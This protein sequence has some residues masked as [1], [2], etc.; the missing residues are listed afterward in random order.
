METMR[1]EHD[2]FAKGTTGQVNE[3]KRSKRKKQK[4]TETAQHSTG[5][6]VL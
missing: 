6:I 5:A 3:H 4:E 1:K 2:V